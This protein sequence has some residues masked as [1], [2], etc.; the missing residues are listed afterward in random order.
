MGAMDRPEMDAMIS[1][2]R[3]AMSLPEL[4]GGTWA[5]GMIPNLLRQVGRL[6]YRGWLQYAAASGG[7]AED[8]V[9]GNPWH[10]APT[11]GVDH[12]QR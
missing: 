10:T 1:V 5:S 7:R 6:W 11:P 4:V 9:M 8:L 3:E 12:A 2:E